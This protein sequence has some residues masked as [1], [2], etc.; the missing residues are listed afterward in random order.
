MERANLLPFEDMALGLAF[1][2]D[3]GRAASFDDEDD[4]LVKMLVGVERAGA[5]DLHDIGAPQALRA[6]ELDIRPAP[7]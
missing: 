2:P 5:R 3:F 7:A 4:L 1:L 6:E